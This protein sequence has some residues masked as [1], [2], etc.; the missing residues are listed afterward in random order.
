MKIFFISRGWP[1]ER[2]PQWGC[3]ERDQALALK[4]LGHEIVALS[5]DARF[6]RY[7]RKYGITRE[8][9][10]GITHY[11]LYAGFWWGRA[12]RT[13]SVSMHAYIGRRLLYY[14]YNKVL[15]QEGKPD[16]L[17]SHYLWCSS[18]ALAVKQ[19][20]GIPLV[21]M[22]HWSELGYGDIKPQWKKW[23]SMVYQEL[24]LLLT[25]SSA[26]QENIL[27]NFGVNSVVVNNMVGNE[28]FYKPIEQKEKKVRF[29]TTGN[30]LPV[31]G[32][33]NLIEAFSRL[34][35]PTDIWELSII[36]GGKEH[37]N[38]QALI[39]RYHLEQNIHLCGR[40]NRE[41]VI[42]KLQNSDVYI[43]S[44]R[45][46]T[47]GVAAVEALACGLPVIA[48]DCGGAR[49]FITKDNGLIC[50]VNNVNKLVDAILYMYKYRDDF[51]RAQIA[52]DCRKRF[53]SEAIGKQL[54]GIFE[55]VIRKS[56]QQ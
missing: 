43:M 42:E 14:L 2:E 49:D 12:L 5:V 55:D 56:N 4:K 46:E 28:F 37:N 16:L 1:S 38:L 11:N 39:N 9:H 47:F 50:P 6:R 52:E 31:K 25:V 13:I 3:F 36:G 15:K 18:M 45:S 41:G 23:A 10:D 7:Y 32:F 19:K 22:E 53:S 44:S 54:E 34:G 35:L 17:Y 51:K 40:K 24:D 33:D 48:T 8:V 26:L 27:K 29:V 20:Y 30:L 21:G